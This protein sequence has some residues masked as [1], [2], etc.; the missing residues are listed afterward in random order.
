MGVSVRGTSHGMSHCSM[1]PWDAM[2]NPTVPWDG[3]DSGTH[4]HLTLLGDS[5]MT[6]G[7]DH[8]SAGRQ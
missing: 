7:K 3:M 4:T 5:E 2:D 6:T 8:H 1:G